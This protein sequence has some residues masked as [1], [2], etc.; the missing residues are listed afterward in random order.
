MCVSVCPDKHLLVNIEGDV[1][2]ARAMEQTSTVT[3]LKFY[4]FIYQHIL[5]IDCVS[6]T[7]L[8]WWGMGGTPH[9]ILG[10]S[11]EPILGEWWVSSNFYP[12]NSPKIGPGA[13][14]ITCAILPPKGGTG[15]VGVLFFFAANSPGAPQ[16]WPKFTSCFGRFCPL[17][18][19][20]LFGL[21]LL[22]LLPI[23]LPPLDSDHAK[24]VSV[25]CSLYCV[26]QCSCLN[27]WNQLKVTVKAYKDC[28]FKL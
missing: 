14:K 7:S 24:C 6:L 19:S 3:G 20:P 28:C 9:K 5:W 10:E 27:Q 25:T 23:G 11:D 15:A 18:F 4:L 12:H 8:L 22:G 26:Q 13:P 16:T 2:V 17:E 1:D 21:P